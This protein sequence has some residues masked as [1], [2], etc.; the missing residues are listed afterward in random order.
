MA[1]KNL[2]ILVVY[3]AIVGT[4]HAATPGF[5]L[6]EGFPVFIDTD[7]TS[8]DAADYDCSS[9]YRVLIAGA[10]NEVMF[11]DSKGEELGKYIFDAPVHSVVSLE[12]GITGCT[13]AAGVW[14]G[15]AYAFFIHRGEN[16]IDS[17]GKK[18]E[19]N[20]GERIYTLAPADFDGDGYEDVLLVGTGSYTDKSFGNLY[21]L[22]TSYPGNYTWK[23]AVSSTVMSI[24]TFDLMGDMLRDNIAVGYGKRVDVLNLNASL[25]WRLDMGAQVKALAPADFDGDSALDDLVVGAGSRVTGVD[26]HK[27]KVWS[28]DLGEVVVGVVP[29][30][31]DG[32]GIIDYHLV[33]A[34]TKIYAVKD[35]GISWEFDTGVNIH[36]LVSADFDGDSLREDVALISDNALFAYDRALLYIPELL[37]NKSAV[38]ENGSINVTLLLKNTGEGTA[39]KVKMEDPVPEG[40]KARGETRWQ[41][42]VSPGGEVVIS[43]LLLPSSPGN[44]TLPEAK[45]SYYDRYGRKYSANSSSV[46]VN[47]AEIEVV[48]KE[49]KEAR[50][51]ESSPPVLVVDTNIEGNL[52]KGGNVTVNII[53]RNVGGSTA[54]ATVE[55]PIPEGVELD[56]SRWEGEVKEGEVKALSLL[57]MERNLTSSVKEVV[58]PPVNVIYRDEGGGV[59]FTGT[60]ELTVPVNISEEGLLKKLKKRLKF[61]PLALIPIVIIFVLHRKGKLNVRIPLPRKLKIPVKIPGRGSSLSQEELEQ[62]EKAF[63]KAYIEYQKQGE[64]PT[65]GD[66]MEKLGV[67]MET[68]KEIVER[69]RKSGKYIL[70]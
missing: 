12:T 6:K 43:Y 18:W 8:L 2:C 3:V 25:V 60:G 5:I 63:V 52:T 40:W 39:E 62:L 24:T 50:V 64:R 1:P 42:E 66:M 21:A 13:G 57:L 53:L 20:I 10:K 33:A 54:F 68:V 28:I 55:I 31:R 19:F 11:I 14:N 17:Y 37:L 23:Y 36:R 45:A 16:R 30:D 61:L 48:Q 58:L 35:G 59:Y 29:V 56:I 34:G 4:L 38:V 67:D 69:V 9:Q 41:G 65:Y 51:E 27:Q 49:K 47:I 15:K 46:G 7:Y 22:P 26:S 70:Q 44:H 32:N